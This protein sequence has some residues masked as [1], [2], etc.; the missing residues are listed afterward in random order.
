MSHEILK[1]DS[2]ATLD[3]FRY[4]LLDVLDPFMAINWP[5]LE[6]ACRSKSMNLAQNF[7]H[8]M[9]FL[10]LLKLITKDEYKNV[11]SDYGN[12][13]L[14]SDFNLST[15]ITTCLIEKLESL[16]VLR[17]V[18]IPNK[19]IR[20]DPV[21]DTISLNTGNVGHE[22]PLLKHFFTNIGMVD[23]DTRIKS[24][25]LVKKMYKPF[26]NE[27]IW[28][29]VSGEDTSIE[30]D[31]MN[32]QTIINKLDTHYKGKKLFISYTHKDEPFKD[33]LIEHLSGLKENGSI[34]SWN[35]RQIMPGEEWDDAIKKNL[36][37]ADI[38]L[39][40]VSSSFMASNYIK[41]VEIKHTLERYRNN[42]VII[43]PI[44]IRPCDFSMLPISKLQ[45][46]PKDAKPI[47]TW[48]DRDE[49]FLNVVNGIK[50][51]L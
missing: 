12:M 45:A 31:E 40:L 30:I 46:L 38:V 29:K 21:Y 39:F 47:S 24:R 13:D 14:C 17:L 8:S 44:I 7:D 23:I 19:V 50:Q 42:E 27:T 51:L 48:A 35:D 5:D 6:D 33:D 9:R 25:L 43:V 10:E 2:L 18:L 34:S 49:A 20:Y 11:K 37:E 3:E 4:I 36:T 1:I 26:F 41:D 28:L 22:Y 32:K 15:Y 16:K